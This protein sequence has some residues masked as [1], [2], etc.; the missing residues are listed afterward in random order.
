M[1]NITSYQGNA[2]Q[3]HS[4]LSPH[5]CQNSPHQRPQI[6]N[7][8]KDMEQ[9][10]PLYTVHGNVNW[11]SQLKIVL[12]T[13]YHVIQQFHSWRQ[14][15]HWFKT[16]VSIPVFAAEKQYAEPC[17]SFK[18]S[19]LLNLEIKTWQFTSKRKHL[20]PRLWYK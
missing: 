3:N 12:K 20:L 2:N 16:K 4:E 10:E 17:P 9:R 5:T 6:T 13:E 19:V 18:S 11:C 15:K 14:W 7:T 1:F 8:S